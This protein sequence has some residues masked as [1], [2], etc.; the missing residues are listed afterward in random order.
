MYLKSL[1]RWL[2]FTLALLSP[3]FGAELADPTRPPRMRAAE[4]PAA[5]AG[6]T[7][8][9]LRMTRISAGQAVAVLNGRVVH[10]GDKVAGARVLTIGPSAVELMKGG[11]RFRVELLKTPVKR[12]AVPGTSILSEAIRGHGK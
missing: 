10:P 3:V 12:P 11:K 5:V 4:R 6:R 9:Q 1:V 8:W 2:G 7:D